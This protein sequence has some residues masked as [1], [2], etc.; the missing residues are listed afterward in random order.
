MTINT[1]TVVNLE[2]LLFDAGHSS[3]PIRDNPYQ[4]RGTCVPGEEE[5]G[6]DVGLIVAS[7]RVAD[8]ARRLVWRAATRTAVGVGQ[9]HLVGLVCSV[10]VIESRMIL[11]DAVDRASSIVTQTPSANRGRRLRSLVPGGT[12]FT[13]RPRGGR[14]HVDKVRGHCTISSTVSA[15]VRVQRSMPVSKYK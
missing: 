4:R 13:E 1:S 10:L 2:Y 6:R 15:P 8:D 9:A 5:S 11:L 7:R 12:W 14:V 3:L